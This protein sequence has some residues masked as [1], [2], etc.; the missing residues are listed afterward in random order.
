MLKRF[1][2]AAAVAGVLV[3][4]PPASAATAES[5]WG[6][7]LPGNCLP[8]TFCGWPNWDHP[9]EGPT[10]TPSLVTTTDW[11]GSVT[12]F[13]FYN[14]TSRNVDIDWY[15]PGTSYAGTVCATPGDADLYVPMTVTRVVFHTRNCR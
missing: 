1:A 4:A 10:A 15:L 11:S 14:Y 5:G 3:A 9:P 12:V 8:G 2:A 13:N 6:R 7:Y